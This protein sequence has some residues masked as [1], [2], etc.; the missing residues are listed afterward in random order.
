LKKRV[1]VDNWKLVVIEAEPGEVVLP[2]RRF[3]D[4]HP[5][6]EQ[7]RSPLF[8]RCVVT[9]PSLL[10]RD[11]NADVFAHRS[12]HL[13]DVHVGLEHKVTG[14]QALGGVRSLR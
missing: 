8:H 3:E 10:L 2:E 7:R 12:G 4:K 14:N 13:S 6:T 5:H 1:R 11:R 9:A